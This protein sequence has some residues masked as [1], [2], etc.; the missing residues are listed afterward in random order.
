MGTDSSPNSFIQ[1]HLACN[2]SNDIQGDGERTMYYLFC[3]GIFY[4][5]DCLMQHSTD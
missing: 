1:R 5:E 4:Q 3:Q 2:I